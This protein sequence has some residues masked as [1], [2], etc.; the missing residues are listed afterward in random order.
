MDCDLWDPPCRAP[1]L[2]PRLKTH[3]LLSPSL[4]GTATRLGT[5]AAAW[6]GGS[7]RRPDLSAVAAA[8]QHEA[9]L[10][11]VQVQALLREGRAP[12]PAEDAQAATGGGRGARS[13][14][15]AV[16]ASG[17]GGPPARGGALGVS[18]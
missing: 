7:G 14:S 1:H 8:G 12:L 17:G 18:L 3:V 16:C 13:A 4:K 10:P 15:G 11:V 2:A 9:V 6:G 5:Q